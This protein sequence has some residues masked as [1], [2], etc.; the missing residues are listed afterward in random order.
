MSGGLQVIPFYIVCD[1][2]SSM[3]GDRIDSVNA[4]L[5]KII[6][7]VSEDPVVSEKALV[8][9]IS[10]ATEAKVEVPLSRAT[11]IETLPKLTARGQ[12]NYAKAV[13]ALQM[14]IAR[15]VADLKSRGWTVLRPF[16]YFITD[17]R[18]GDSW[19]KVHSSWI[20]KSV[21]PQAPNVMCF[22]VA[23]ADE[24]VLRRFATRFVFMARDE[25]SAS[26]ALHEV[27]RFIPATMIASARD[28]ES[29]MPLPESTDKFFVIDLLED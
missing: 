11:D 27:M 4:G 17:G 18:P 7:E 23:E 15:D 25:T 2:S 8:S 26:D 16:V 12:T 28:A 13:E 5:P 1:V 9:V 22:G 29:R 10:F 19:R 3:R 24:D 20:N 21:N 6:E 14:S